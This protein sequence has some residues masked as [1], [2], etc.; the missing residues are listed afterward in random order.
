MSVIGVIYFS[1][2]Q[3]HT[4]MAMGVKAILDLTEQSTS[5]L[6]IRRFWEPEGGVHQHLLAAGPRRLT[7]QHGYMCS[8][9]SSSPPP[10]T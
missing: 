2:T 8:T 3:C 1:H 4:D 5:G 10:Q 9:H 6:I 7:R